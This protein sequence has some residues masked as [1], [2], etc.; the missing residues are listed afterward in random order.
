[1]YAVISYF[2]KHKPTSFLYISIRCAFLLWG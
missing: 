1:M 2:M